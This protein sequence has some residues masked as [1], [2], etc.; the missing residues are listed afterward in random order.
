MFPRKT[1]TMVPITSVGTTSDLATIPIQKASCLAER[2]ARVRFLRL[3]AC[4]LAWP[5]AQPDP[6]AD[7]GTLAEVVAGNW[8]HSLPRP[9]PGN[10]QPNQLDHRHTHLGYPRHD[11]RV[12][13]LVALD[14]Q[15]AVL[16]RRHQEA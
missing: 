7:A 12:V 4:H 8:A 1:D 14:A 13:E 10:K 9:L 11:P 16:D 2:Y 6:T 3:H 5:G 15:P